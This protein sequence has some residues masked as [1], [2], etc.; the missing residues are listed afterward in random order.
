[1]SKRISSTFRNKIYS[2]A[3]LSF[4]VFFGQIAGVLTTLLYASLLP[5]NDFTIVVTI[6]ASLSLFST[7]IGFGMGNAL[8]FEEL[9]IERRYISILIFLSVPFVFII[10]S[11]FY[12]DLLWLSVSK[13]EVNILMLLTLISTASARSLDASLIAT[14]KYKKKRNLDL[15]TH[16]SYLILKIVF[17][18]YIPSFRGFYLSTLFSSVFSI[19]LCFLVSDHFLWIHFFMRSFKLENLS[20]ILIKQ[21]THIV[22][23]FP[24]KYLISSLQKIPIYALSSLMPVLLPSYSLLMK[25][26]I[27]PVSNVIVPFL[28]VMFSGVGE[29]QRDITAINKFYF[30]RIVFY[31]VGGIIA[32][33][34]ARLFLVLLFKDKYEFSMQLILFIATNLIFIIST[35]IIFFA[36]S[37]FGEGKPF[38]KINMGI[39]L[40]HLCLFLLSCFVF[41]THTFY[42]LSVSILMLVSSSLGGVFLTKTIIR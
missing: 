30:K 2:T 10:F 14:E 11:I 13:S 6:M 16:S 22:H 3:N 31:L 40:I 19:V 26:A 41:R 4:A 29:K 27:L 1:M 35:N 32:L 37:K 17:L 33:I 8:M 15:I 34:A 12:S 42:F 21:K 36:V 25:I 5:V 20:K 7:L 39:S 23:L 18:L 38:L 9:D 24:S 28:K